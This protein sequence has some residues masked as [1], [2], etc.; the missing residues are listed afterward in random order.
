MLPHK[1]YSLHYCTSPSSWATRTAFLMREVFDCTFCLLLMQEFNF[2]THSYL[3][4]LSHTV[5]KHVRPSVG[6]HSQCCSLNAHEHAW[7]ADSCT[8]FYPDTVCCCL[9]EFKV[10]PPQSQRCRRAVLVLVH[11]HPYRTEVHLF[12][13]YKGRQSVLYR[14]ERSH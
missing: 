5:P 3:A 9:P 2:R 6:P 8:A 10:N 4:Q 12:Q 11:V 13:P 14:T 7:V 1:N